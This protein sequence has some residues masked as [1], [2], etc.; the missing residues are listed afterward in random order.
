MSAVFILRANIF[1]LAPTPPLVRPTGSSSVC[2]LPSLFSVAQR[3]D[4]S[5]PFSVSLPTPAS[6][7]SFADPSGRVQS[8]PK[9]R[10]P[11]YRKPMSLSLSY[12]VVLIQTSPPPN[13][14]QILRCEC[15]KEKPPMFVF[16]WLGSLSA[17]RFSTNLPFRASFSK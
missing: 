13:R 4:S 17:P 12:F 9:S 2:A 7:I 1:R 15:V 8:I 6:F 11:F 5:C 10:A 3:I 16:D 14:G